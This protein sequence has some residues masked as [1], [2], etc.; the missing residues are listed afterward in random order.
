M[1]RLSPLEIQRQ[2]FGTKLRGLDPD[3]VREFL[4]K[5]AEQ[6]EEDARQRGEL[7]AQLEQL[8]REVDDLRRRAGAADEAL[9]I[10]QRTA[11]AT[12]GKAE[13]EGQ[14]IITQAQALA[15]RLIDEATRR[16]ENIELLIAQLRSSRRAARADLMRISEI[17]TGAARDDE[18]SELQDSNEPNLAF[19]RPRARE[20]GGDRG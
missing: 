2:T 16:V 5:I 10:A 12:V 18:K 8:V 17:L 3:D 11:E 4:G 1:N 9:R 7:R 20:S 6:M 19:L 14:R 15:D 13:A